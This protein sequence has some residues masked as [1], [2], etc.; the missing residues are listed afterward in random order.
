MELTEIEKSYAAGLLE[1]EGSFNIIYRTGQGIFRA[2]VIFSNNNPVYHFWLQ[3]RF[4]GDLTKH[5]NSRNRNLR[6]ANKTNTRFLVESI[7]PYLTGKRREAEIVLTL[8]DGF[9]KSGVPSKLSF[10]QQ[11]AFYD[12]IKA[13]HN[14]Q[15]VW[16]EE[17]ECGN[18]KGV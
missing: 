7:L 2:V 6:W 9:T 11:E 12:E 5:P 3:K 13:I 15:Y 14:Q 16:K 10:E 1:G 8:L 18:L 4:G 17:V